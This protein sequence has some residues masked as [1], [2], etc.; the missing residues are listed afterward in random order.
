[1]DIYSYTA[2]VSFL[3]PTLQFGLD[4]TAND[5]KKELLKELPGIN[6]EVNGFQ[7]FAAEGDRGIEPGIPA[8]TLLYHALVSTNIVARPGVY[9]SP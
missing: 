6:R 4:L 2:V 5:L 9:S 7:D 1:V 8:R 3:I